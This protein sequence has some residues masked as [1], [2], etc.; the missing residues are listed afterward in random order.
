M[1][2]DTMLQGIAL[3]MA[4]HCVRNTHLESLHAGKKG[5]GAGGGFGDLEMK[6]LMIQVVDRIYT[7]LYCC[8]YDKF[9]K[10][11]TW[12]FKANKSSHRDWNEPKLVTEWLK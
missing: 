11:Q 5:G 7:Y 3:E 10:N 4:L 1:K 6:K 8:K 12:W 2:K 9:G